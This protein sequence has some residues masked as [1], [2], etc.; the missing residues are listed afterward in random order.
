MSFH[1]FHL[2]ER[3]PWPLTRSLA[4]FFIATSLLKLIKLNRIIFIYFS[5]VFLCL[6]IYLWWRDVL[7]EACFQGFHTKKTINN[8]KW[9]IILFILREVIFFFSFFW[10]YFHIRLSPD[11]ELGNIWPP[12][13][14][15]RFNPFIIPLL[16]TVILLSSGL[17]VTVCHHSI[18][19]QKYYQSFLSLLITIT[20]GIYFTFLQYIEYY[21]RPFTIRDCV[22]GSVFFLITGFHGLHVLVGS[23]FLLLNLLRIFLNQLNSKHHFRFEANA[24]YWHFVDVVWL[25][26]YIFIYWWPFYFISI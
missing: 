17:T 4:G 16:N 19:S 13:G 21:E 26:L 1:Q 18:I 9:G 25:F 2:V 24:W 15:T 6:N 20:L 23:I 11:T 22:Y 12:Q 3:R 7:R 14:I 8:I 5:M 10:C